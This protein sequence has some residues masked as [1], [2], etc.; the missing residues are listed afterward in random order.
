MP[1]A[2]TTPTPT[3]EELAAAPAEKP[4]TGAQPDM[5]KAIPAK[6]AGGGSYISVGN[7]MVVPVSDE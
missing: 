7:G 5:S 3:A 4:A 6:Q 2:K 1:T